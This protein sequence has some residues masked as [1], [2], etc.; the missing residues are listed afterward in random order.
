MASLT[1]RSLDDALKTRLRVRAA[2]HG[3]SMEEEAR[4]ILRRDLLG[5]GDP[6]TNLDDLAEELFGAQRGIDLEL[7]VAAMPPAPP[8]FE[9]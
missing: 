9:G 4:H 1:I 6:A 8:S 2:E 5:H 7:R 3:R